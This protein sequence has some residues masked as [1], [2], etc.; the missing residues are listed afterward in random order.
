MK[1]VILAAGKGTRINGLTNGSP[2]SLLPLRDTTLLGHSL[3]QLK[4]V[5]LDELIIVTGHRRQEIVD[6]V[7]DKWHGTMEVVF[8]PHFENTNV[9]YSLWLALPYL[10]GHNFLFLHADTVFSP[11]VLARLMAHPMQAEM[12]FAV[13]EHPCGDE[14]MKVRISDSKVVEVTKRMASDDADGEFLGFARV[15]GTQIPVLRRQAE[16]LFEEGMFSAFFELAVQRMIDEDG[17]QVE[18]ADMTGLQWCE[19]DFSEDYDVARNFFG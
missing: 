1:G 17:L 7:R 16:T 14:E 6:Y 4:N 18:V 19:V 9:L 3:C 13:D 5:G 12:V 2:K 10:K 15:S 8:N 11:E